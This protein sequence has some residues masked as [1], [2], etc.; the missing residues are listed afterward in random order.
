MH[1]EPKL[2]RTWNWDQ[3]RVSCNTVEYM[4]VETENPEKLDTSAS[5]NCRST[6][7]RICMS[8]CDGQN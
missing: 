1:F 2:R 3:E 7:N 5:Q 6:G 4:C 8:S